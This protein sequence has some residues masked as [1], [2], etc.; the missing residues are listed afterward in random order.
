MAENLNEDEDEDEKCVF[1]SLNR[2]SMRR[3]LFLVV[4]VVV[5]AVTFARPVCFYFTKNSAVADVSLCFSSNSLLA[6][7]CVW[8]GTGAFTDVDVCFVER[9]LANSIDIELVDYP[10]LADVSICLT[11]EPILAKTTL[12]IT[13]S[14]S[15]ADSRL[16]FWDAPTSFTTD[17]YIKGVDPNRLSKE[18]KVAVVYALLKQGLVLKHL[19]IGNRD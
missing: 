10:S 3:I 8:I 7:T 4:F 2:K 18:A 12:C 17:I 5:S 16:G 15:K 6:D 1:T 11:D 14:F 9:P 19:R 13:S